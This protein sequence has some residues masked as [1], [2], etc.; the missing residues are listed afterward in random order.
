MLGNSRQ[1]CFGLC[2]YAFIKMEQSTG[3]AYKPMSKTEFEELNDFWTAY[4]ATTD[5]LVISIRA[6][7]GRLESQLRNIDQQLWQYNAAKERTASAIKNMALQFLSLGAAVEGIKKL[8]ESQSRV[9]G[10]LKS[11]A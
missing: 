5:D 6:D 4:M 1:S 10:I 3:K 9:Q 11:R 7:V 2:G 8:A